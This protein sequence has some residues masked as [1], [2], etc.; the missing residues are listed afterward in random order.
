L[1]VFSWL[2]FS[3][4][5]TKPKADYNLRK[6]GLIFW[7]SDE[8]HRVDEKKSLYIHLDDRSAILVVDQRWNIRD[9]QALWSAINFFAPYIRSLTIDAPLLE[10][11]S[12]KALE[13]NKDGIFR[14]PPHCL[15]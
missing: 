1:L 11:V 7:V 3:K 5:Q 8:F 2:H 14:L 4:L 9:V 13:F 10:L 15:Q 6:S 12:L